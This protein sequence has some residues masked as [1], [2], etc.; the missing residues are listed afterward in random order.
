MTGSDLRTVQ[1]KR[2]GPRLPVDLVRARDSGEVVFVVGAGVSKGSGLPLFSELTRCVYNELI[3]AD[4]ENDD[5]IRH[6]AEYEA[7]KEGAYDV[8]LGL[9]EKSLSGGTSLA[10]VEPRFVREAVGR[11]LDATRATRVDRHED[12]LVLSQDHRGIP[13]IVTTNFDTLFERAWIKKLATV[14]PMRSRAGSDLPGPGTPAFSGILHIH[15]RLADPELDP[16]IVETELILTDADFGDAYLRSGWAARFLYD[17]VRK[18]HLVFV[19]YR[20]EDPPLKY[21]LSVISADRRRYPDLKKLYAFAPTKGDDMEQVTLTWLAKDITPITY[22]LDPDHQAL[23]D[24]LQEW[25]TLVDNPQGWAER[26]LKAIADTPYAQSETHDIGV[27]ETLISSPYYCTLFKKVGADFS[28]VHVLEKMRPQVLEKMRPQVTSGG[29]F[30]HEGPAAELY[31]RSL[32]AWIHD[33]LD[34]EA[35]MAWAVER[36]APQ[37]VPRREGDG[38]VTE[39]TKPWVWT[40]VRG[41]ARAEIDAIKDLV[42]HASPRWGPGRHRFW[43]LLLRAAHDAHDSGLDASAYWL[44]GRL[45]GGRDPNPADI[46]RLAKFVRPKLGIEQHWPPQGGVTANESGPLD[47]TSLALFSIHWAGFPGH[48]EIAAALPADVSW[49]NGLLHALIAEIDAVYRLAGL[50]GWLDDDRDLVS[51]CIHFVATDPQWRRDRGEDDPDTFW[52]DHST[53]VRLTSATWEKLAELDG[54]AARKV[55]TAWAL[56]DKNLFVRLFLHALRNNGIWNGEEVA[57]ALEQS[58]DAIF[59]RSNEAMLLVAER[60][61][62]LPTDNR[63]RIEQRARGGPPVDHALFESDSEARE[64]QEEMAGRRLS[65]IKSRGGVLSVESLELVRTVQA[66]AGLLE[67]S[68]ADLVRDEG[69]VF[70]RRTADISRFQDREGNALV[71]AMCES[72]SDRS[73]GQR[74]ATEALIRQQPERVLDALKSADDVPDT[75]AIW[76]ML[77]LAL[78]EP[79]CVSGL[80]G[81]ARATILQS[82]TKADVKIIEH[83]S[84]GAARYLKAIVLDQDASETKFLA[85]HEDIV[86]SAWFAIAE[87]VLIGSETGDN[88]PA[89]DGKRLMSEASNSPAGEI[90]FVG[91]ALA[92]CGAR[93]AAQLQGISAARDEIEER[94]TKAQGVARSFVAARFSEW[95]H[96]ASCRLPNAAHALV[97]EPLSGD[98]PDLSLLDVHALYG[99]GMTDDLY[100]VLEPIF[101]HEAKADR[102]SPEGISNLVSRLTWR[103]LTQ[104]GSDPEAERNTHMRTTLRL[105]S[106]GAREAAA[107]TVH[108]WFK[109]ARQ[110]Q[111]E[112]LCQ[113]VGAHFFGRV[114]PLDAALRTP[115][116]SKRLSWIPATFGSA[117]PDAVEKIVPLMVPFKCWDVQSFL[118]SYENEADNDDAKRLRFARRNFASYHWRAWLDLVNAALGPAPENI[119]VDLGEWLNNIGDDV[120]EAHADYRFKTLLRLTLR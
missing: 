14:G 90:A 115:E 20:A 63:V 44:N 48:R 77:L 101:H 41:F 106:D 18:Y 91:L 16:P 51:G 87:R 53:L 120:P 1:Y 69:A 105:T 111:S 42:D 37:H 34:R 33:R 4:L 83:A 79:Q 66:S 47:P 25:A 112:T 85:E 56:R 50:I 108:K 40:E 21:L 74:S 60:W 19:G 117:F 26:R 86:L 89:D 49:L 57:V 75:S 46:E 38:R 13:R 110:E 82:I 113:K 32:R 80:S 5:S 68:T 78:S 12:L 22:Y 93:Q 67:E 100:C 27:V 11:A 119:P 62:S 39:H 99:R 70:Q 102:L 52:H 95:L 76:N 73:I 65:E 61:Q 54:V 24:T 96:V 84:L 2:N 30:A 23:Y 9:L 35:T 8:V 109:K 58:V 55:A 97:L 28:W 81:D 104:L 116:L 98:T 59:W 36:L 43:T 94:L 118:M 71:A 31:L 29:N 17:L 45:R 114:W 72:V 103:S 107:N 64:W 3:G 92:D 6:S 15:G 88:F 7:F 10:M